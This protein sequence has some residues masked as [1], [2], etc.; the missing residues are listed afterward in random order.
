MSEQ[1][2][3]CKFLRIPSA[4][5]GRKSQYA[6]FGECRISPAGMYEYDTGCFQWPVVHATDWCAQFSPGATE[7]Q[8]RIEAVE[9]ML[10]LSKK[11]K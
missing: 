9:E 2:E 4:D 7:L 11:G 1:C 3:A 8:E 5:S 10:R 6:G